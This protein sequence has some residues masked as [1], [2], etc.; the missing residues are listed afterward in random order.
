[1]C[2]SAYVTSQVTFLPWNGYGRLLS[3]QRAGMDGDDDPGPLV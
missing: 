3:E 2:A 1:M